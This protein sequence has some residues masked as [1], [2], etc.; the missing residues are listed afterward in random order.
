MYTSAGDWAKNAKRVSEIPVTITRTTDGEIGL[1]V[2]SDAGVQ[3]CLIGSLTDRLVKMGLQLHDHVVSIDGIDMNRAGLS[4]VLRAF[5]RA[6]QTIKVKVV[7]VTVA[8]NTGR[9]V[10]PGTRYAEAKAT[11]GQELAVK[12]DSAASTARTMAMAPC[13]LTNA[14]NAPAPRLRA[15]SAP[16]HRPNSMYRPAQPRTSTSYR[17]TSAPST[18]GSSAWYA[19]AQQAGACTK[20]HL[21]SVKYT[22]APVAYRDAASSSSHRAGDV[23]ESADEPKMRA[24]SMYRMVDADDIAQNCAHMS[25]LDGRQCRHTSVPGSTWCESHACPIPAC[26]RSKPSRQSSCTI[27]E[28]SCA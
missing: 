12:E 5:E 26:Q 10:Q 22:Q 6:D 20:T 7:R 16:S 13:H 2:F 14:M 15:S 18:A 11:N 4:T 9:D 1:Q 27:H 25:A 17:L 28:Q 3:G 23:C 21:A 19:Q 8:K 24:N